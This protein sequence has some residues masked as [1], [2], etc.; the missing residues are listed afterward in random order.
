MHLFCP[1]LMHCLCCSLAGSDLLTLQ[2]NFLPLRQVLPGALGA[3]LAV[4]SL[5]LQQGLHRNLPNF[6]PTWQGPL[7]AGA[8]LL[9][10]VSRAAKQR[11]KNRKA[12]E[13]S[14]LL[15]L[16]SWIMSALCSGNS[17]NGHLKGLIPAHIY[18]KC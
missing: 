2:E 7:Y 5:S 3:V 16:S 13:R 6:V 17:S 12:I 15:P 4:R 18:K 9:E 14:F 10:H 11:L 8:V 1:L